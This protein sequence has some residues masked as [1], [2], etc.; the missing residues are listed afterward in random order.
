MNG[1]N[2]IGGGAVSLNPGP[3]WHAIGTNGGGADILFQ[4]TSG[5]TAVWDMSGTNVTG[6]GAV[7]LNAGTSWSA[8]GL[9]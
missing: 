8:L 1:T 4:S 5:Q 6:G 7:N 9:T 3:G 2:I